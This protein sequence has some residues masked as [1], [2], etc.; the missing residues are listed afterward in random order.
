VTVTAAPVSVAADTARVPGRFSAEFIRRQLPGALV[1]VAVAYTLTL[2]AEASGGRGPFAL[3]KAAIP[4]LAAFV[5]VRPWRS[6][7][8]SVLVLAALIAVVALTVCTVTPPGWFGADRAASY[9]L[10][11]ALFVTVA[12]YARTH[13]RIA[14]VAG[15]IMAAGGIQFFW[16]FIPWWGGTS[17]SVAM[18]G[19]FYWHNQFAAFL[20]APALLGFSSIA[21]NRSPWRL[22]G[23]LVT[24]FAV[25]GIV[26]STSRAA[27]A[28]L[29]VGWFVL[30]VSFLCA[31]RGPARMLV[32]LV[33]ASALCVVVTLVL[34]GPPFFATWSSPFA[35]TNARAAGGESVAQNT[36][37]RVLFWR[38]A[39]I[40]FAHHPVVGVGYGALG[41][42]S[43]KLTPASWPRSPLAHDDYLQALADGGL[44]LGL[45]FLVAAAAAG[46]VLARRAFGL[47]RHRSSEPLRVGIVVAAAALMAHAAVDFDWSYPALF[48]MAAVTIGLVCAPA[49]RL[50]RSVD[51][52]AMRIVAAAVLA[53]AVVTGAIAGHGGGIKLVVHTAQPTVSVG[54]AL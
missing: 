39:A 50:R 17:A 21:A 28:V 38:E 41:P 9:G 10:A 15:L 25:A 49:V 35:A 54:A 5:A 26:Y 11:A 27:L 36:N 19:T 40:V 44:L 18:E 1:L 51:G 52:G 29:A 16:S 46:V 48:A 24:P 37:V 12:T 6:V 23:W 20:L 14:V 3:T 42:E 43:E 30:A 34:V 31:R 4:V 47:L 2:F 33:A 13:R 8:T 22:V 53:A 45:P 32:R 7:R